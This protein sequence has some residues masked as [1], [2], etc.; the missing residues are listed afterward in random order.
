MIYLEPLQ[1]QHLKTILNWRNDARVR[2]NMYDPHEISLAEHYQ[3]YE[4]ISL[5]ESDRVFI[6]QHDDNAVGVVYFSD[7]CQRSRNSSWGFYAS[8]EAGAGAGVKMEYAALSYAFESLQLHKLNCEVISYNHEVINL[9]KKTGFVIEG[10]FRDFHCFEDKYYDVIRFGMLSDEWNV[11]QEG[12]EKRLN[13]M[14]V[15]RSTFQIN[16]H[17]E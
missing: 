14:Y 2:N 7:Y 3:W 1:K 8:S 4:R 16:I 9:H 11:A 15:D 12:L 6:C 5:S 13:R 17:A 10:T